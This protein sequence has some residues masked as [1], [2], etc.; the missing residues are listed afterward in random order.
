MTEIPDGSLSLLEPRAGEEG[1]PFWEATRER[2][3]VLPHSSSTGEPFWFPREFV[4]GTLE[5]DIEWRE[6]SG[7]ATVYAVSVQH[8]PGP[9]RDPEAGPYAV[10]LVDLDEGVRMMTNV[11]GCDP[12][13][14]RCGMAVR[15]VW[16]PLSDGRNLPMFTPAEEDQR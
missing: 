7:N 16:H 12:D 2:R 13:E 8:K 1:A 5:T 3:L 4:P 14:V 9:G 15:L 10:A 11:V 6:A